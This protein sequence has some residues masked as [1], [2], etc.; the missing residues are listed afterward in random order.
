M[1]DGEV[2]VDDFTA[3]RWDPPEV[4]RAARV[5]ANALAARAGF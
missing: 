4:A 3:T 5:E 1:V 2:L